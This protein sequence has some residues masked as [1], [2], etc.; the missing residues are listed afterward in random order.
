MNKTLNLLNTLNSNSNRSN[1]NSLWNT[2]DDNNSPYYNKG[3]SPLYYTETKTKQKPYISRNGD[4][5]TY[6]NGVFSKN[7]KTILTPN[8]TGFKKQQFQ[9]DADT[10][11]FYQNN[12]FYSKKN[13]D[14]LTIYLSSNGSSFHPIASR[15]FSNPILAERFINNV[16][17]ALY[18]ENSETKLLSFYN[19][20]FAETVID[21]YKG[22]E[23][24]LIPDFVDPIITYQ[25]EGTNKYRICVI[26]KSGA[27]IDAFTLCS[28]FLIIDNGS[29]K[30]YSSVENKATGSVKQ[31]FDKKYNIKCSVER[32]TNKY[33][34]YCYKKDD[35]YYEDETYTTEITFDGTYQ[36]THP[37]DTEIDNLYYYD[38]YRTTYT[39]SLNTYGVCWD[40]G[41]KGV[42]SV[43]F[44]DSSRIIKTFFVEKTVNMD[45]TVSPKVVIEIDNNWGYITSEKAE[46][47]SFKIYYENQVI[48]VPVSWVTDQ[49]TFTLNVE[50][51][52]TINSTGLNGYFMLDDGCFY[53]YPEKWGVSPKVV[54]YTSGT[55]TNYN[56]QLNFKNTANFNEQNITI[57]NILKQNAIGYKTNVAGCFLNIDKNYVKET[58]RL[59]Y[60]PEDTIKSTTNDTTIIKII[61]TYDRQNNK[62]TIQQIVTENSAIVTDVSK[63]TAVDFSFGLVVEDQNY[64]DIFYTYDNGFDGLIEGGI[65]GAGI[66]VDNTR[67]SEGGVEGLDIYFNNLSNSS[68]KKNGLWRLLYNN[69]YISG[70]AYAKD[71]EIGTLISGWNTGITDVEKW[72]DNYLA[73][74]ENNKWW[75]Y[76]CNYYNDDYYIFNNRY[77]IINTSD[78]YNAYDME[79]EQLVHWGSDWNNRIMRGKV[80]YFLVLNEKYTEDPTTY[81][82]ASGENVIY[83]QSNNNIVSSLFSVTT[84][85]Y[86]RGN[87]IFFLNANKGSIDYFESNSTT[88][89]YKFTRTD[90]SNEFNNKLLVNALTVSYPLSTSSTVYYYNI[91]LL[92]EA[93]Y[94]QNNTIF[95]KN[96]KNISKLLNKNDGVNIITLS[97]SSSSGN[98]PYLQNLF[99]I[100]TMPYAIIKDHIYSIEINGGV[101]SNIECVV[102]VAGMSYLGSTTSTAFFWSPINRS[103][104]TFTGDAVL[105]QASTLSKIGNIYNHWYNPTTQTIYLGTDDGL[106]MLGSKNMYRQEFFNVVDVLFADNKTYIIDKPD[107]EYI[108]YSIAH[109]YFE[110]SKTNKVRLDTGL[111]S[112]GDGE[113]YVIPRWS[114]KLFN[115]NHFGGVFKIKSYSLSDIGKIEKKEKIF[116]IKPSDWDKDFDYILINYSPENNKGI[117]LGVRL[118]SDFLISEIIASSDNKT[119][120]SGNNL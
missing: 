88:P 70:L 100:Q 80:D 49:Y 33:I 114:F 41:A 25:E 11:S 84:L 37:R 57:G 5:Y 20:K 32:T 44:S 65:E 69:G 13:N 118:E 102:S 86:A 60:L 29:I 31:I 34:K 30:K 36:P 58:I 50:E 23:K 61:T 43:D 22:N 104:Y 107:D 62:K 12:I 94:G 73:V 48:L 56:R 3:L 85:G 46:K 19:G 67:Y 4:I 109:E 63:E 6:T 7:G 115:K 97:S 93:I 71:G 53:G 64:Y 96:G 40:K 35:K 113:P 83:N 66:S 120:Q 17:L 110:G 72:A 75:L 116:N 99:I 39:Y 82:I 59:S 78:Y 108:I 111:Y 98:I 8:R 55:T 38:L 90:G 105:K 74:K 79:E 52:F 87:D 14:T 119:Q 47:P 101:Y 77:F 15:T 95:I 91:P 92:F 103:I 21:F 42:L 26:N 117:G 24:V 51:I 1:P 106:Y 45:E 18:V 76:Q 9:Y 112:I 2:F 54:G 28:S 16:Y 68:V 81:Y 10:I 27:W 89:K